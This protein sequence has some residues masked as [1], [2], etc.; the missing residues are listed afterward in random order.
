LY[1]EVT[2]VVAAVAASPGP[3]KVLVG[4]LNITPG[5][6][7]YD[8]LDTSGSPL[9]DPLYGAF[10]NNE[11][12][13]AAAPTYQPADLLSYPSTVDPNNPPVKIDY[14]FASPG[15]SGFTFANQHLDTRSVPHL[16]DNSDH[17]PVVAGL[18][19]P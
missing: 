19:T 10:G 16:E 18:R 15:S 6:T 12:G 3:L 9:L 1:S 2:Q 5:Q 11:V 8:R 7:R 17:F 4:D 13:T 14:I